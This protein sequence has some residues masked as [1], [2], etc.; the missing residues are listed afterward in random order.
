MHNFF[1]KC[2]N[3]SG[4]IK[5]FHDLGVEGIIGLDIKPANKNIKSFL[6]KNYVGDITD[7]NLIN[8]IFKENKIS[9]IYHLAA[10][11]RSN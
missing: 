11:W 10:I 8:K 2:A 5:K 6:Y 1:A 7:K 3:I 9:T 4:K